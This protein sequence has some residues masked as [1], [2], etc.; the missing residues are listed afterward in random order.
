MNHATDHVTL[1]D[2]AVRLDDLAESIAAPPQ[3][4]L[5]VASTAVYCDLS[6]ESIRRLL[7]AGKLPEKGF[8]RQE[9]ITFDDFISNRFGAN[10]MFTGDDQR[11]G[12]A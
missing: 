12:V 7:A 3:R 8:V 5:G 11:N 9:E 2:L 1:A 6:T 10:Y 4:F